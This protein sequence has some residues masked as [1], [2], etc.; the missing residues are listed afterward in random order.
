MQQIQRWSFF[1]N[2]LLSEYTPDPPPNQ[3]RRIICSVNHCERVGPT[4][5]HH[6][7]PTCPGVA[8]SHTW[9]RKISRFKDSELQLSIASKLKKELGSFSSQLNL[10]CHQKRSPHVSCQICHQVW[11]YICGEIQTRKRKKKATLLKRK[12]NNDF[13]LSPTCPKPAKQKADQ[14]PCRPQSQTKQRKQP[15]EVFITH[16]SHTPLLSFGPISTSCMCHC[17]LKF[18]NSSTMPI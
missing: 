8:L 17:Q 15:R 6:R 16:N 7:P 5:S 14:W 1:I 11:H 2:Q 18:S 13:K 3:S 4:K 12:W 10:L 9:K